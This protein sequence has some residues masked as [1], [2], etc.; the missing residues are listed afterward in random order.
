MFMRLATLIN[1]LLKFAPSEDK[2]NDLWGLSKSFMS[3][4]K[5]AFKDNYVFI[6][7]GKSVNIFNEKTLENEKHVIL[8]HKKGENF[9]YFN[10]ISLNRFIFGDYRRKCILMFDLN[11]DC[12]EEFFFSKPNLTSKIYFTKNQTLLIVN[13]NNMRVYIYSV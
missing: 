8:D 4:L 9:N 11:G 2:A 1:K 7:D 12:I 10:V 3:G 13:P 6:Y 5:F